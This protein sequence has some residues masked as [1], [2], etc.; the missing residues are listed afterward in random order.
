MLHKVKLQS[1]SAACHNRHYIME[2]PKTMPFVEPAIGGFGQ[3]TPETTK[4]SSKKVPVRHPNIAVGISIRRMPHDDPDR[5]HAMWSALQNLN[6][7]YKGLRSGGVQMDRSVARGRDIHKYLR[8]GNVIAPGVVHHV[9]VVRRRPIDRETHVAASLL[10]PGRFSEQEMNLVCSRRNGVVTMKDTTPPSR[11][12]LWIFRALDRAAFHRESASSRAEMITIPSGTCSVD[13]RCGSIADH[14]AK[15]L[16][17]SE[18]R[19]SSN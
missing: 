1:V 16:P 18:T 6:G 14:N 4:T 2:V 13:V 15:N 11:E 19:S 9:Q 3:V 17:G 8:G 12:K 5:K 10:K 7:I